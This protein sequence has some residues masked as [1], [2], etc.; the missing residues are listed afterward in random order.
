MPKEL[1]SADRILAGLTTSF[2][3]RNLAYLPETGSTNAEARQLA[4]KGAPDGTLVVAD[5]QTAGRGRLDRRWEAPPGSS[6]LLSLIFRPRLAPHQVQRLT[7]L[8]GLAAADAV[9]AETG[10]RMGLKWPNDLMIGGAKTGGILAEVELS[11]DLIRY[12]LVGVG[13]NVNLDPEQLPGPLL[14]RATSLSHELGRPVAR[15]AL[16]WAFLEAI[17]TRYLTLGD[18]QPGLQ[19]EW[20]ERLVTLGQRVTISTGGAVWQGFA[21]GV[22]GDGAL[23]VRRAGGELERVMAGDV[24]VR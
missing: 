12:A 22:D 7:M 9:E 4:E 21:E 20:A 3:G 19:A 15:L 17:E 14:T 16:L 13:V 1:L 5:H 18:S 24:T 2:V 23:L 10:L 8:G 11:G 6:L